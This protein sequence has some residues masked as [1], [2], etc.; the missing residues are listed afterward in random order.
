MAN[1]A[2][3]TP[4]H[5]TA[6]IMRQVLIAT[7]PGL[8]ASTWF[9]GWGVF[10]NVLL[11]AATAVAGE[12]GL[13]RL[14]HRPLQ[15]HRGGYFFLGDGSA[16]VTGVLLG[17]AL[18]PLA[19]WWLPVLGAG[20]AVIVAKHLYGGL[21][22]NLFNPAMAGLAMLLVS[23]PLPMSRWLLPQP[24]VAD[25]VALPGLWQSVQA[26][27]PIVAP[28]MLDGLTGATPLA[29]MRDHSGLELA[30]LYQAD[31]LFAQAALAGVGWEWVNLGFL[32]GGIWLLYRRVFRWHAP[33]AMLAALALMAL[34]FYD[35]GSSVSR[36]SVIFHLLSG[37]TMLGAFFIVT[38]PVTCASSTRGRVLGGA[39][40]GVLIFVLRGWGRYPDGVAFAVL[41]MNCV[42]PLI[43]R[44]TVPRSYGQP[45]RR[46]LPRRPD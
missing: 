6:G 31:P 30:Q 45:P 13:L 1:V 16:L 33:V 5:T 43:D 23:F 38:D 19:P 12:A 41:L 20:F 39:L 32:V 24:L 29:A 17:L 4:L 3:L 14:R 34:L 7:L 40:V 2:A 9:F 18:P 36:G 42:A 44:Y 46:R 11:C 25:G 8:A 15:V 35:G 22:H 21:G 37:A 28:P 10:I 26:V 27:F